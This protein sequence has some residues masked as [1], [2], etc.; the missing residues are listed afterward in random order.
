MDLDVALRDYYGNNPVKGADPTRFKDLRTFLS[1]GNDNVVLANTMIEYIENRRKTGWTPRAATGARFFFK[2]GEKISY[3]PPVLP[4]AKVISLGVNS[5]ARAKELGQEPPKQP[6]AF[7]RFS[8]TFVGHEQPMYLL[9]PGHG[10][11]VDISLGVVMGTTGRKIPKEKALE[12]VAGFTIVHDLSYR[13]LQNLGSGVSPDWLMGSG[14]DYSLGLGP[15]VVARDEVPDPKG[16]RVELKVN[17][18]VRQA[19]STSDYLFSVADVIH[20][21]S[22]GITLQAGDLLTMGAVSA[23]P[24][25]ELGKPERLLKPGDVIEGTI[26]K[27]GSLKNTVAAEPPNGAPLRGG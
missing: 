23:A 9:E 21:L 11:D 15:G 25:F 5:L 4:G 10:P 20:H 24:G 19:G 22:Q 18:T 14:G 13:G 7:G 12:Y 2:S 3:E 16:L 1:G 27:V 6:F 8:N 26:D 17:G